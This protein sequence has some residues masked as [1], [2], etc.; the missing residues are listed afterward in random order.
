VRELFAD[1]G[2]MPRLAAGA[3]LLALSYVPLSVW[4][5]R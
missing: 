1:A 2:P 5:T 4:R 3:V